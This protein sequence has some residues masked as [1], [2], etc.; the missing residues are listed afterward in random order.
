MKKHLP[1]PVLQGELPPAL[2]QNPSIRAWADNQKHGCIKPPPIPKK[3]YDSQKRALEKLMM[4][5]W[6]YRYKKKDGE[7]T[8]EIPVNL[9]QKYVADMETYP[10]DHA[11][12]Q[13]SPFVH[14]IRS[15]AKRKKFVSRLMK[16]AKAA[17][18][19][20]RKKRPDWTSD[21]VDPIEKYLVHGWCESIIVDGK[22]WP[23]LCCFTWRMLAKFLSLC[24]PP[25]WNPS[26]RPIYKKDARV[27]QKICERLGLVPIPKGKIKN[28][29]FGFGEFKFA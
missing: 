14:K 21:A 8:N 1:W 24:S 6:G 12:A 10:L 9:E 7:S 5:A 16:K 17:K 29:E 18:N 22:R 11:L 20:E 19:K 23:P 27:L 3:C 13:A 28:V 26:D 4:Q 2:L 15:A 25:R